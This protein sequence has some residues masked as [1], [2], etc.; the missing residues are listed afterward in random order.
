MNKLR[1]LV[2]HRRHCT[3][4]RLVLA[5]MLLRNS[6]IYC[7]SWAARLILGGY[8]GSA[9]LLAHQLKKITREL[10]LPEH[11]YCDIT[12]IYWI[13]LSGRFRAL[14]RVA[15]QNEIDHIVSPWKVLMPKRCCIRLTWTSP[16]WNHCLTTMT[17]ACLS[18]YQRHA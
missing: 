10:H 6:G 13:A 14:Y 2:L 8:Q 15:V 12:G 18:Q 5:N 9:P 4:G 17:L 16:V 11:A 1:L 7:C 3:L